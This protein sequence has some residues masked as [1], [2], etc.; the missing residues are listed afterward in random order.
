MKKLKETAANVPSVGQYL[1]YGVSA[2]RLTTKT[3]RPCLYSA[4]TEQSKE[5]VRLLHVADHSV[6]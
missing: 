5:F 1:V 4:L 2:H 3:D 6:G